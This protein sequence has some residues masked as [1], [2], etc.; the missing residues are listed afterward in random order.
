MNQAVRVLDSVLG[1]EDDYP[2]EAQ[3]EV[4]EEN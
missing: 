3:G 1:K 4:H 2:L